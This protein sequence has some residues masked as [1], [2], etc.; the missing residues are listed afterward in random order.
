MHLS[1]VHLSPLTVLVTNGVLV[2]WSGGARTKTVAWQ[3]RL[4]HFWRRRMMAMMMIILLIVM[5]I[6][7]MKA[8]TNMMMPIVPR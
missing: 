1:I 2:S 7:M 5:L 8:M 3:C 4:S 6:F